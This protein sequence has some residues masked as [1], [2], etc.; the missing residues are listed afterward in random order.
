MDDITE[1]SCHQ[2]GSMLASTERIR[3]QETPAECEQY[4]G[5]GHPIHSCNPISLIS[6]QKGALTNISLPFGQK[7]DNKM[8]YCIVRDILLELASHT[9][10]DKCHCS[11]IES[12]QIDNTCVKT[13]L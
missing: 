7:R 11:L 4:D 2:N 13:I 3:G 9:Y 8:I 12:K 1:Q 5:G 6:I 10:S